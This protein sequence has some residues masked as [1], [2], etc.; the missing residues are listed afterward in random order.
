M[1]RP[2][3]KRRHLG[4][5]KLVQYLLENDPKKLDDQSR[6][7]ATHFKSII[8]KEKHDRK[9]KLGEQTKEHTSQV[10]ICKT[11]LR[12]CRTSEALQS[13]MFHSHG[14]K[15][16][17]EILATDE[18]VDTMENIVPPKTTRAVEGGVPSVAA[19]I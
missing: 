18:C 9:R 14:L 5:C 4:R 16:D 8:E 17:D 7:D 12:W 6:T 13:H 3:E 1:A 10:F 11:C 19:L 2:Y 15:A